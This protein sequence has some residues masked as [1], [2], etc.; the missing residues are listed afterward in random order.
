[1][2]ILPDLSICVIARRGGEAIRGFLRS[3][4][5]SPGYVDLQVI[6]AVAD[7]A[8]AA[9]L[10]REFNEALIC[11]EKDLAASDTVIYNRTLQLATGR[12]LALASEDVRCAPAALERLIDFMEDAPD[13]GLVAPRLLLPSGAVAGSARRFHSPASFLLLDCLAVTS[14]SVNALR[15]RHFQT[16]WDRASSREAEWLSSLFLLFR[17][18]VLEEIGGLD[19]GFV[20]RYG[21]LDYCFR[22]RRAGWHNHF[23]HDAEMA[24]TELPEPSAGL[25]R[26]QLLDGCR[27]LLKKGRALFV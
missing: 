23:L 12:Y 17:R 25:E 3:L 21:D 24:L 18:E 2:E 6:V 7:G 1:M 5:E 27:F 26:G 22:A 9:E 19:E 4:F 10:G 8:L 16:D 14:P 13:I 15:R 11:E 20:G